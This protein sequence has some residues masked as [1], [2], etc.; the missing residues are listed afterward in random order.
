MSSVIY[1]WYLWIIGRNRMENNSSN[2]K[3]NINIFSGVL[4]VYI[5]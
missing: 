1:L 4:V 3:K 5:L 2:N